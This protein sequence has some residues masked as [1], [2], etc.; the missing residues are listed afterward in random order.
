MGM[1]VRMNKGKEGR[2]AG[3]VLRGWEVSYGDS[4]VTTT[5]A[6]F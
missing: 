1:R 6:T 2:H 4:K 5:R 3:N